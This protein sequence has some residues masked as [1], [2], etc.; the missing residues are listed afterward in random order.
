MIKEDELV[1]TGS[2]YERHLKYIQS[3]GAKPE[4]PCVVWSEH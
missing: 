3:F 2:T 4:G 1:G